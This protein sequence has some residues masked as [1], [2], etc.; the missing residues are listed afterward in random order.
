MGISELAMADSLGISL[1]LS[2]LYEAG[3]SR[4][5]APQLFKLSVLLD[6]HVSYF[7]AEL[8]AKQLGYSDGRPPLALVPDSGL[9]TRSSS[10]DTP[11]RNEWI[12]AQD[13][14]TPSEPSYIEFPK[15]RFASRSL[16]VFGI[17]IGAIILLSIFIVMRFLLRG[18]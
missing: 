13:F 3:S 6:V 12:P 2:A 10:Q 15:Q 16:S 7:F 1:E 9:L 8:S 4:I 11:S 17:L 5:P 18:I 14:V